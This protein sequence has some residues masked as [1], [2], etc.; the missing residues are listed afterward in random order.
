MNVVDC[1]KGVRQDGV[2]RTRHGA[3]CGAVTTLSHAV[4]DRTQSTAEARV[5]YG[6]SHILSMFTRDF[7]FCSRACDS[8]HAHAPGRWA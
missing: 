8:Q 7:S 4:N 3:R 1:G 2:T 6:G 5:R